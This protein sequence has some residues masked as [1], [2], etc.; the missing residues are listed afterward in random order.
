MM[1]PAFCLA[2]NTSKCR[3]ISLP[4]TES[5]ESEVHEKPNC[6]AGL[7]EALAAMLQQSRV[8]QPS[9]LHF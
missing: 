3:L 6:Q 5:R 2:I 8:W 4:V 9:R 1:T 7:C